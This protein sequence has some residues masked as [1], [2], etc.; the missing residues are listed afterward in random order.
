MHAL[1]GITLIKRRI[2]WVRMITCRGG[3]D[4]FCE[5]METYMKKNGAH[6]RPPWRSVMVWCVMVPPGYRWKSK[7]DFINDNHQ[8]TSLGAASQILTL[9]W[10]FA[11]QCLEQ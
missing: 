4:E 8:M 7:S 9:T 2:K 3:Q 1:E 5:Y 6:G 11:P 10:L